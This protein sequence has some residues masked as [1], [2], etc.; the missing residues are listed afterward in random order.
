MNGQVILMK[1]QGIGGIYLLSYKNRFGIKKMN[2]TPRVGDLLHQSLSPTDL[3]G[4]WQNDQM[5]NDAVLPQEDPATW[6]WS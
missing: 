3:G 4:W 5:V 1:L 2:N 6:G